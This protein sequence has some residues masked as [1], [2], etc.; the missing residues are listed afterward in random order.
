FGSQPLGALTAGNDWRAYQCAWPGEHMV[1]PDVIPI[2]V[3]VDGQQLPAGQVLARDLQERHG[4]ASVDQRGDQD[5]IALGND[6]KGID[7]GAT[8]AH[9][10]ARIP[11]LVGDKSDG[12]GYIHGFSIYRSGQPYIITKKVLSLERNLLNIHNI[13]R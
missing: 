5:H 10:D 9:Q 11:A 13:L 6:D 1:A 2:G 3:G 12:I 4:W 8:T 7:Q